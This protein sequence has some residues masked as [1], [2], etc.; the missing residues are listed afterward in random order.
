MKAL[1]IRQPWAHL[2]VLGGKDIENRSWNT[3]HRGPFLI[4]AAKGCTFS[5]QVSAG[6]FVRSL[7]DEKAYHVL[8]SAWRA[9][10]M[11]II[12]VANLVDVVTESANPWFTGPYGFV[13]ENVRPL[14]FTPIKGKLG[15]FEVPEF[16]Q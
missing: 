2:I 10:R 3:K 7:Q 12:A 6:D 8:K 13:I 15:F 9:P 4:H 16:N 11:G 5:E 14:P 1:S